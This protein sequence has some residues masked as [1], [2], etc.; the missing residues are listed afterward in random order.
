MLDFMLCD[1]KPRS[2]ICILFIMGFLLPS[3][4]LIYSSEN[5]VL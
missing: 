2:N 3:L 1:A 4:T 5:V